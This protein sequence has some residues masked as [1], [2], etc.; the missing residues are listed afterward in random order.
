MAFNKGVFHFWPFA[1]YAVAFSRMSR[2]IVTRASS[3]R[4]RVQGHIGGHDAASGKLAPARTLHFR[5]TFKP[6]RKFEISRM[7][8]GLREALR[9]K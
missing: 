1:M 9:L 6:Q 5:S 8:A 7:P 4:K 2:S 3:A